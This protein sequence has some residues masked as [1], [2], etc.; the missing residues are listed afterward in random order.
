MHELD[1][2]GSV[3]RIM[4]VGR[5][6]ERRR[7]ELLTVPSGVRLLAVSS[8]RVVGVLRDEMDV[9]HVVAWPL[10]LIGSGADERRR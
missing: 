9:E 7:R 6:L 5:E 3:I 8:A 2:S 4:R 1:A 10:I